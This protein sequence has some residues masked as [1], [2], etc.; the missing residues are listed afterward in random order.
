MCLSDQFN[1]NAVQFSS[2]KCSF[3]CDEVTLLTAECGGDKAFNVFYTDLKDLN[4]QSH[5]L[6]LQCQ[7]PRFINIYC[8]EFLHPICNINTP[9]YLN[10]Q[11]SEIWKQGMEVCKSKNYYL[12]GNINLSDAK[13]SC[14]GLQ[15]SG[16]GWIGVI[17]E[18][19]VKSDQGQIINNP[20]PES[21]NTCQRCRFED[22]TSFCQYVSCDEILTSEI[23]CSKNDIALQPAAEIKGNIS[24]SNA[25]HGRT[26]V[27]HSF[28]RC[29]L[30]VI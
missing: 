3:M 11:S 14:T 5:C 27:H 1:D 23:I 10:N 18:N 15:N 2:S 19:F 29:Y 6:S 20:Y 30:I 9:V 26:I 24:I 8:N 21:F 16:P 12:L 4:I 25:I 22:Q 28:N 7:D 13:S 17:K